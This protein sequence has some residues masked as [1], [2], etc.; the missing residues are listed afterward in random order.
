MNRTAPDTRFILITRPLSKTLSALLSAA[1]ILIPVLPANSAYG[2]GSRTPASAQRLARSAMPTAAPLVPSITATKTDSF[3]DPDGDNKAEPGDTITY[4][5]TITNNG[6]DATNVVFNDTVDP[7][8]TLVPGSVQTQPIASN[9]SYNVL[10]NV[11]IQPNAAAGLLANDCDPDNGGPCNSAGLTASGPSSS[12]NGGDVTVNADGSFSY[13]PP[14][15]YE[16]PDSF[17]YTVTDPTGKTDTATATFTVNEM[18][19]FVDNAAPPG[20]GRLTSPFNNLAS[21]NGVGDPDESF[22]VIYILQG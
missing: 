15:G 12:A 20:D 18:V 6:T 7:N 14:A 3:P 10:G 13:N 17:T 19:W 1:L 4:T 2:R 8:T 21:L 22:D 11:R 9:D 16:G 5:V